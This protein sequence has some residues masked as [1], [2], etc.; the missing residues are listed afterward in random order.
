MLIILEFYCY[1]GE[2]S[3]FQRYCQGSSFSIS[4]FSFCYFS[5]SLNRGVIN[6][7][8]KMQKIW[9]LKLGQTR[10]IQMHLKM[11]P[12]FSG[13]PQ[14]RVMDGICVGVFHWNLCFFRL[15]CCLGGNFT[16]SFIWNCQTLWGQ[17]A[18]DKLCIRNA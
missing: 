6:N 14:Y 12:V 4:H 8:R 13:A 1:I 17:D 15:L 11:A 10:A 3:A 7:G 9:D 16:C 2:F 18:S 5:L